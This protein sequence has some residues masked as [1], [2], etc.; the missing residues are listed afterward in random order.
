MT[1]AAILVHVQG[2]A[3]AK[4]RLELAADYA[5][6]VGAALIG[7]GAEMFETPSAASSVGYVDGELLVAEAEVVQRDLARAEAQFRQIAPQVAR[8]AEWRSGVGYPAAIIAQQARAADLIVAAP[9]R[10]QPWGF[11][12]HAD[13]GDLLMDCG[14]PVLIAPAG[15]NRLDA[16]SVVVAWKDTREAR[17]AVVDALPILERSSQVL[18]A[19]VCEGRDEDE[20]RA[21][22]TD[23]AEFLAGHGIK[24]NVAVRQ[25]SPGGV[26]RTLLEIAEMQDAGLIVAGGY[27][28]ARLREWMFG[29]VTDDMLSGF[30]KAVLLSH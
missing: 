11:Q 5:N 21:S 10:T 3:D 2:D 7:I 1:H 14:R 25:P 29:G 22:V 12:V 4:A 9:R 16:S 17:R 26:G 30:P 18:I 20:A 24:S 19:E 27:G 23:V 8:G 28:H 13:P 6:R 15:A